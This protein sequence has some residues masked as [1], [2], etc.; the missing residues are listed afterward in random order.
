MFF[1]ARCYRPAVILAGASAFAALCFVPQPALAAPAGVFQ[2]VKAPPS[3]AVEVRRRHRGYRHRR[4]RSPAKDGAEETPARKAKPQ[5]GRSDVS[6]PREVRD[7]LPL[8]AFPTAPPETISSAE[9]EPQKPPQPPALPDATAAVAPKT[10]TPEAQGLAT[11]AQPPS[12]AVSTPEAPSKPAEVFGPPPPPIVWTQAEIEAARR[13]CDWR[14]PALGVVHE[15]LDPLREGAC[16]TPAPIRLKALEEKIGPAVT[17]APAPT[18]TCK[19]GEAMRRWFAEVVQPKAKEHLNATVVSVGAMSGYDCRSRNGGFSQRISQHAYANALDIG[20]FVTARGEKIVLED[21]WDAG[22]ERAAFLRAIHAGA[23]RIFGTT[24]GPEANEAH[25]NHLHLDMT[26]RR[27]PL[28]DFTGAEARAREAQRKAAALAAKQATTPVP[29]S[30]ALP[31]KKMPVVYGPPLPPV[32][33]SG[34]APPSEKPVTEA[35]APASI[36]V[37]AAPPAVREAAAPKAIAEKSVEKPRAQKA[38]E[39]RRRKPIRRRARL[40]FGIRF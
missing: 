39:T 27:S 17:F 24:L 40:P 1:S 16:G 26:E 23:C 37:P 36:P 33:V 29:V 38:G 32:P 14:L 11:P 35:P 6:A 9:P 18:I 12:L 8:P 21:H 3:L 15:R 30:G 19:L 7:P 5:G 10:A 2:T 22:D 31:P 28:C 34:K 13:D 20:S 4:G 25:S